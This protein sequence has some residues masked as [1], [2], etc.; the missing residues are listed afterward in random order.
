MTVASPM[1]ASASPSDPMPTLDSFLGYMLK[2]TFNAVHAN[3][4]VTLAQFELRMVTY[5]ALVIISEN[6][7][8]R[9]AEL[10]ERLKIDR[11]NA[12]AII[13]ELESRQLMTRD[14]HP[15]DRRSYALNITPK[16][17][18][19]CSAAIAADRKCEARILSGLTEEK[20]CE[21]FATL[22]DIEDAALS[23]LRQ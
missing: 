1:A 6:R 9:Q 14:P 2:R 11:G 15:D 7:G 21:L 23:N 4:T 8:L 19:L 3:L 13:D 17:L 22:R 10:A 18:D 5:S 20:M 12:V 16:G